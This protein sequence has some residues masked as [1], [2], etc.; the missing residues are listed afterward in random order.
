MLTQ[1]FLEQLSFKT[2]GCAIE[3][4]RLMGPGLLESVYHECMMEELRLQNINAVSKPWVPLDYKKVRLKSKLQMDILVEG[5]LVVELKSVETMIP[6]YKAQILS[7]MKLTSKYKGLLINFNCEIIK[8]NI[9]AM[10]QKPFFE[11]PRN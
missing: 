10:V 3:V 7:H 5:Q 9:F 4:H 6:V 2:I 8:S 11:L 1:T